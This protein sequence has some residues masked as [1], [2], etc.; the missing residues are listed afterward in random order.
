MKIKTF[1]GKELYQ[2]LGSG[3]LEWGRRFERQVVLAQSACGFLWSDDVKVDLFGHYLDGMAERYFNKQIEAWWSQTPTLQDT[4]ERVLQAF[5]SHITPAQAMNLFTRAKDT[6]NSWIDHFMNLNAVAEASGGG[7]DY[8]VLNNIVQYASHDMPI[9]LTAQMDDRRTD[10]MQQAEELAHF[11][12][13]WESVV[14]N[15]R[16]GREIVGAIQY[17]RY[18]DTRRCYICG[19]VGPLE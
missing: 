7:S 1:D 15:K 4:M 10:Y 8:L 6:R 13:A 5:K 18:Q 12:Q 17:L 14:M 11:A 9:L 2:D 16:I 3:F 19:E